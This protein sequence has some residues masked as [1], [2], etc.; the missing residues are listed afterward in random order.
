M[1]I[2]LA[3]T[4]SPAKQNKFL[5]RR[6]TEQIWKKKITNNGKYTYIFKMRG[7]DIIEKKFR[8][9]IGDNKPSP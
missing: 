5:Q 8:S 7:P 3:N 9:D 2:Q 6:Q 1:S 4:E